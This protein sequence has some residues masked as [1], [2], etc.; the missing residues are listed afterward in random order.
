MQL[1]SCQ[2]VSDL[3]ENVSDDISSEL[4][5]VIVQH[6]FGKI[7]PSVSILLHCVP[8]L[9]FVAVLQHVIWINDV[10]ITPQNSRFK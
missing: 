4:N 2:R 8:V 5:I 10:I 9:S 6:K 3:P 1:S 7:R